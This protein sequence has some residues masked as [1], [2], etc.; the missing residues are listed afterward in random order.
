MERIA[1]ALKPYGYDWAQSITF[2]PGPGSKIVVFATKGD[3]M[4]ACLTFDNNVVWVMTCGGSGVLDN[5]DDANILHQ[6]SRSMYYNSKLA[7]G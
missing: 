5:S 6:R 7:G 1:R 4:T 3:F 2:N